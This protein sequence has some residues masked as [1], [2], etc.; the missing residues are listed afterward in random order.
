MA[1]YC[2]RVCVCVCNTHI[3]TPQNLGLERDKHMYSRKAAPTNSEVSHTHTHQTPPQG[4]GG[5]RGGEEVGGGGRRG[6]AKGMDTGDK[7]TEETDGNDAE[8]PCVRELKQA[9]RGALVKRQ[10]LLNDEYSFLETGKGILEYCQT[11]VKAGVVQAP[12]AAQDAAKRGDGLTEEEKTVLAKAKAIE[13]KHKQKSKWPEP[14]RRK[15]H[16][17]YLLEEMTWL[18]TDFRQERKWKMAVAKKVAYAVVKWHKERQNR[19]DRADKDKDNKAKKNAAKIAKEVKRFWTQIQTLAQHKQQVQ[20]DVEKK[21]MLGKHLDF[22]VDQTEKYSTMIAQDLAAPAVQV[23]SAVKRDEVKQT[24]ARG[25]R[26]SGGD[27][28]MDASPAQEP[29]DPT[30]GDFAAGEE[31]ED[32]EE[33]ME[34]AEKEMNKAEVEQEVGELTK[35]QDMPIAEL[36]AKYG[37]VKGEAADDDDD[38]EEDAGDDDDDDDEDDEEDGEDEKGE[39]ETS[40]MLVDETKDEKPNMGGEGADKGAGKEGEGKGAAAGEDE[41]GFSA[42]AKDVADSAAALQ[43]TGHTLAT[44]QVKTTVPFLLS[45][46]LKMREYQHIAL[47]WMIALY[48]KGLNG[49]LADEMGLGKTIMTISVLAHLAC[50]RG[51]WGPHL[52]VVPTSLL[53][54]WEIE[55]KRWC[56]SFKILTYYGSQKERKEKRQGWSKANSFHVCIT[57]YKMVVQ[58]QKMFRRKKWKYMILDEAH[59]IKNFQSQRWQVLLGFRSKRRLLLTG[60]PLQNN[61]MELWSLLHFLMP[62][63]FTSHSEFKDWFANPLMQMVEGGSAINHQLV[64]RLHSVLRPFIL[65][66]LKKDVETQMPGKH[67]HIVECPLSKRQRGLYDEFMAAG[68]TQAKLASG[69]LLEVINV[70]MQLRKVCNH[71]D[72]F[73][74]R[75]IVSPLD[76]IISDISN[77]GMVASICKWQACEHVNLKGLNFILSELEEM[78]KVEAQT[79]MERKPTQKLIV[80][81]TGTGQAGSGAQSGRGKWSTVAEYKAQLAARRQELK[82]DAMKA[83]LAVND[84]RCSALPVFGADLCMLLRSIRSSTEQV[85]ALSEDAKGYLDYTDTL[86]H[87]VLT[88]EERVYGRGGSEGTFELKRQHPM[89]DGEGR[90]VYGCKEALVNYTCIIPKARAVF[91][92]VTLSHAVLHAPDSLAF[93]DRRNPLVE[94]VQKVFSQY[95]DIV[96]PARIRQQLYFPDKR[97][98][99]YDCGKLQM[100]DSML[101]QLKQGGHRVLLFTQMSKV[102]DVVEEFLCFHGHTYVRLDGSTKIEHRQQLVERFNQDAKIF[103]FISSTRAGGVGINLTGADT[104][105]FYDSD[106]NPAMDRQAQDRCHRIGQTREVHIYRMVSKHTVEE[107]ILKKARQKIQL[108]NLALKEG[109][110]SLFNPEMFKKMDVRE[111]FEDERKEASQVVNPL[112]HLMGGPGEAAAQ[113]K[114]SKGSDAA[115]PHQDVSDK[116]WE[117]ATA[118]AEDERDVEALKAAKADEKEELADFN[119]EEGAE[120][121]DMGNSD[122]HQGKVDSVSLAIESELTSVQR[123]ALHFL[124]AEYEQ[125]GIAL[126][127]GV[128]FDKEGWE[129]DQ[130][131]RIRDRDADRLIDEDEILYY[132]VSGCSQQVLSCVCALLGS[133]RESAPCV[134]D[135]GGWSLASA[136]CSGGR[137]IGGLK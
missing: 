123:Y 21:K 37:I 15:V 95:D 38:E 73:E 120:R 81:L 64:N 58:D 40:A 59:N 101:R 86:R 31:E 19:A 60:T 57:S 62:H 50:E 105:I 135:W 51:I 121:G 108:E 7:E 68:S 133:Q 23:P 55:F 33:T 53:L 132:E 20:V 41:S 5:S 25:S 69:N 114:D 115:K 79:I 66:R 83:L 14:P 119:E 9:V 42:E 18:A 36:L 71:P 61:L 99:Q 116:D 56:P 22:L 26:T 93:C 91:P 63:I 29:V 100:L 80:E 129:K 6:G 28:D 102:L 98:L 113:S 10:K 78:G 3:H 8:A 117:M 110:S 44:A 47:D 11:I 111:L 122:E 39:S 17:D 27:D 104:V 126:V 54:N 88:A 13:L 84:R 112:A 125:A 90:E 70:L 65:R 107:N 109:A 103:V 67:E 45:P 12:G 94:Q 4:C 49:I 75:P 30:D 16:H 43:P 96:R 131:R 32:D 2:C 97:L 82:G 89:F 85:I 118:N 128:R 127:E 48:D 137:G 77:S 46:S 34:E 35:E 52:I 106:W 24:P 72:L 87:L 124:E 76:L 1:K 92:R 74:E 130:L 136:V 134:G